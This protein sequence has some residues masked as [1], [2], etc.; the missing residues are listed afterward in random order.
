[1]TTTEAITTAVYLL[2]PLALM[3]WGVVD[4]VRGYLN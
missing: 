3:A 2:V 1:M 4:I